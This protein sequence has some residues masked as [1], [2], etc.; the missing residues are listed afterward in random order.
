MVVKMDFGK[1]FNGYNLS[2]LRKGYREKS[3]QVNIG[4]VASPNEGY[5]KMSR[6]FARG[7]INKSL[8]SF[9]K[10]YKSTLNRVIF[11]GP[12]IAKI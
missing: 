12:K 4:S 8:R 11:N 7:R 1:K 2:K 5:C 9:I 10:V 3:G 6:F